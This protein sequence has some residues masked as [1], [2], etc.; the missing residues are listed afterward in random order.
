MLDMPNMACSTNIVTYFKYNIS[1]IEQ[2]S[3][4]FAKIKRFN[5]SKM[6]LIVITP[7]EFFAEE[8]QII[9]TLFEEGLD[10]LHLRKPN[11][12]A[13]YSERL[14]TLIPE[15][16]HKRIVIHDHY[17]LKTEFNLMGIH[18]NERNPQPAGYEGHISKTCHSLTEVAE[19]K[20]TYN[21]I[22]L[23]P[24]FDS[25]T[26]KG[27]K[28]G[29]TEETLRQAHKDKIIDG[30]VIAVGGTTLEKIPK[31]KEYGF[32]GVAISG[33]LWNKFDVRTDQ[34]YWKVVRHFVKLR[35]IAK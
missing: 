34:D 8:E 2:I 25:I 27:L 30:K 17:Y 18:L 12:P 31:L 13:S 11:T 19:N 22:F 26:I 7:P 4:N 9:T 35:D 16:Y 1:I 23:M 6:K 21:Y 24:I 20:Q 10:I 29:Y 28:A 5:K 33:D 32:G 3:I 15:K 14:L